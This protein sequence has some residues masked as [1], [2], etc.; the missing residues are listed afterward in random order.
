MDAVVE[1]ATQSSGLLRKRKVEIPNAND[2][3]VF[4]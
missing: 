3:P 2:C 4:I 1:S